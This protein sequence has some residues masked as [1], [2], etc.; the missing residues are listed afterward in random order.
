VRGAGRRSHKISCCCHCR[1]RHRRRWFCG[2]PAGDATSVAAVAF[3]ASGAVSTVKPSH[4]TATT[5]KA[6][7]LPL[8]LPSKPIRFVSSTEQLRLTSRCCSRHRCRCRIR[9]WRWCP[10]GHV[11][12]QIAVEGIASGAHGNVCAPDFAKTPLRLLQSRLSQLAPSP[13][14]VGG[15]AQRLHTRLCR[16]RCRW[17]HRRT[18]WWVAWCG[19]VAG[20]CAD[21]VAATELC[22]CRTGTRQAQ[23]LLLLPLLRQTPSRAPVAA[24]AADTCLWCYRGSRYLRGLWRTAPPGWAQINRGCRVRIWWRP[25]RRLPCRH[26]GGRHKRYRRR[27]C[28]GAPFFLDCSVLQQMVC[29]SCHWS[30]RP[31]HP[32]WL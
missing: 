9:S 25:L 22:R 23:V 3:A 15:T 6:L 21:A 14:L 7:L 11:A 27:G 29:Q 19:Q 24:W 2:A 16:W 17:R 5:H 26:L 31:R 28:R 1:F 20:A 12:R 13:P 4:G 8:P 32:M 10:R 30:R 18:W